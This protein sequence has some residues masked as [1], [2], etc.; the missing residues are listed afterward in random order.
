MAEQ[1]WRAVMSNQNEILL[2]AAGM[3]NITL[4]EKQLSDFE[5]YSELLIEWN[6]K[7][8]LTAITEPDEIAIKHFEDSL[9]V[10]KAVD[11]LKNASVI[12]VGTGAGFPSVPMNIYRNDLKMTLLDSLNKRINFLNEVKKCIGLSYRTV[13]SRAE[14]SGNNLEFREKFDFAVSRAVAN[15]AVLSEYCLPFVKIGGY[16]IAMKGKECEDE[17]NNSER[18]LKI[19]GGEIYKITNLNLSDGSSRTLIL[20][21][22]INSTPS[23]Y[24]R[25]NTKISK[26]PL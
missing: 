10:F 17:I 24:P 20:V 13:H 19:L 7:I 3:L 21:K 6:N 5:K 12:D 11:F 9:T 16:F 22:K 4:N 2:K 15:L 1:N 25:K 18:A 8:N 23:K 14:D 26:N